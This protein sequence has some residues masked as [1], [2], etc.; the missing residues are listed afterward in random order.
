MRL[1]GTALG[2]MVAASGLV[3]AEALARQAPRIVGNG[4]TGEAAGVGTPAARPPRARVVAE[5]PVAT[6]QTPPPMPPSADPLAPPQPL[7]DTATAR[8]LVRL[9]R[10]EAELRSMTDRV[11]RLEAETRR[12]RD[13]NARLQ[14]SASPA[15]AAETANPAG[16]ASIAGADTQGPTSGAAGGADQ[17]EESAAAATQPSTTAPAP[18]ATARIA[19]LPDG[20]T[21]VSALRDARLS[22][23]TR[24]FPAA[25]RSLA[26]LVSTWPD[27]PE[28]DEGR[29]LLGETRFVQQDWGRAA[30]AYVDY[31]GRSPEG[32][33]VAEIYIRLAG[34]FRNVGDEAQRC[35]ALNAF[36]DGFPE[37]GPVMQA[38][39]A[40]EASRGAAC[41]A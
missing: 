11:E 23:Q 26:A 21:P 25:E 17:P 8:A 22:L 38:R 19:S 28:A 18:P 16:V 32:R 24:D 41:P 31:L 35:R 27:A 40:E 7:A 29:W 9:E 10:L 3:S 1:A 5:Q 6:V 15:T 37:A 39:Y 4:P 20:A 13:D 2:L 36:R 33:R 34:V 30:E 14:A 12:L